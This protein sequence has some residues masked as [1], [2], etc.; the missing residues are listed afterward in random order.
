MVPQFDATQNSLSLSAA[1]VR[2]RF[3]DHRNPVTSTDS[4]TI[5]SGSG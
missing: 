2:T 5:L 1:D 4:A 3:L